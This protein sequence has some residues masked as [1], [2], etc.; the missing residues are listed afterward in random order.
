VAPVNE[1]M[2][3]VHPIYINGEEVLK[4]FPHSQQAESSMKM[5]GLPV[6][7]K[8]CFPNIDQCSVRIVEK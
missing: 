3:P 4:D 6:A 2:I 8:I 7:E 5:Y 1:Q